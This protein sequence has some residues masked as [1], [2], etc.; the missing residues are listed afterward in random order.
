MPIDVFFNEIL[1][2]SFFHY[3]F[4]DTISVYTLFIIQHMTYVMALVPE[5]CSIGDKEIACM[6]V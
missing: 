6:S 4:V 5:I 3:I 2:S 1:W